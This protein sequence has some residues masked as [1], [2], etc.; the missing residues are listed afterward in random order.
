MATADLLSQ[1]HVTGGIGDASFSGDLMRVAVLHGALEN[2]GRRRVTVW[3]E[4]RV[5]P[6]FDL[7]MPDGDRL[8]AISADGNTLATWGYMRV[9]DG[10]LNP[11]D[12]YRSKGIGGHGG[13][14]ETLYATY[15]DPI[16]SMFGRQGSDL[17]AIGFV[18][19]DT[20]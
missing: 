10:R 13:G 15:G 7:A 19:V 5:K 2:N 17:D 16:V 8:V 11:D 6:P 9:R 18:Q 12:T 20:E 3:D 1:R 4:A 14:R